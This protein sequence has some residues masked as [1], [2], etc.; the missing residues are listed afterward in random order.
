MQR[1]TSVSL[2]STFP[3]HTGR[4]QHRLTLLSSRNILSQGSFISQSS[5]SPLASEQKPKSL[6]SCS[7]PSLLCLGLSP[8]SPALQQALLPQDPQTPV[9]WPEYSSPRVSHPHW[10]VTSE[11]SSSPFCKETLCHYPVTLIYFLKRIDHTWNYLSFRLSTLRHLP[12]II[13]SL[14]LSMA[15]SLMSETESGTR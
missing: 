3:L 9:G 1:Q 14:A 13:S 11:V 7:A 5:G 4:H 12:N 8:L 15:V 10:D 2:Y 6:P